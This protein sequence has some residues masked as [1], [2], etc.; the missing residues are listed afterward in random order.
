M[1]ST[2]LL[3]LAALTTLASAHFNLDYPA[4]RGFDEDILGTSP[5]GGQDTVS[6]NRTLYPLTGGSIALTMGHIDANVAVYIGFGDS[7][8]SSF[9]T[10]IR[11]TFTEQGLGNFCMTGIEIPGGSALEGMNATIQV[12]TNGDPDGGL[13][14]C[15]DVTLSASATGLASGVCKNGTGV[16]ITAQSVS[17]DPNV[18]SVSNSTSGTSGADAGSRV[19]VGGLVVAALAAMMFV[20]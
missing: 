6:T 14:N 18:T 15:A 2:T 1:K 4:A 17:G 10:V 9:N 8:G 5:C 19:Q 13:Y 12:V 3:A 11:P 20:Y 7:V 16:S